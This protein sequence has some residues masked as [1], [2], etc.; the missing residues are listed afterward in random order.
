M[1]AVALPQGVDQFR[2]LLASAGMQPLLELVQDQQHLLTGAEHPSLADRRQGIDQAQLGRQIGADLPQ[3]FQEPGLRLF[4]GRL[5][6]NGQDV[7][8][9]PGQQPCFDQ[10]RLAATR[11]SVD[12][13]HPEGLVGVGLF[14]AI[15][16][17]PNAVGQTVSVSWSGKQFQE[18]VGVVSIEGSQTF[19]DDLD[20]A[21][22][23]IGSPG[24]DRLG[25]GFLGRAGGRT[26]DARRNHGRSGSRSGLEEQAQVFR[27]VP[28]GA[29]PLGRPLRECLQADPFQF[30]GDRVVDLAGWA[31]FGGGDQLHDFQVR[32]TSE[33]SVAR[34]ATR[35]RRRP[36]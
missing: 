33:W 6:V 26:D 22:V 31:S 15:L 35:R 11:G 30:L 14:D 19:G 17:E 2:V 9:Q 7:L 10:R 29:V 18:E 8:R 25:C 12:Q 16:P 13:P 27:H 4:R 36:G 3:R 21:L 28:G 24:S 32:I 23:R 20:W 5:D 1:L 34:S